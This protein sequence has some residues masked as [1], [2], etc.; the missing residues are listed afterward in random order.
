MVAARNDSAQ[1]PPVRT[2]A[3]RYLASRYVI[4]ALLIAFTAGGVLALTQARADAQTLTCNGQAVTISGSTNGDDVLRGTPGPDVF[5]A[6]RGNDTIYGGGGD[7]IICG[8]HGR[9][10]IYAGPG[11][12]YIDAGRNHDL[13]HGGEGNDIILGSFGDDT[14]WGDNGNDEIRGGAGRRD[15]LFGGGGN[16]D[17]CAGEFVSSATCERREVKIRPRRGAKSTEI[18]RPRPDLIT[19][20][21]AKIT[22]FTTQCTNVLFTLDGPDRPEPLVFA[23]RGYPDAETA[24]ENCFYDHIF[25]PG[26]WTSPL[27][28]DTQYELR[29][30]TI[31][32]TGKG[33]E[34]VVSFTTL[35]AVQPP[36]IDDD[37]ARATNRGSTT[38]A[39][40]VNTNECTNIRAVATTPVSSR[41]WVAQ[42]PDYPNATSGSCSRA[43][44]LT[45][46]GA[47]NPLLPG[48][49]YSVEVTVIDADGEI[50]TAYLR[51]TTD[52]IARPPTITNLK[53]T[54]ITA[55]SAVVTFNTDKC[56]NGRH[57]ANAPGKT[58]RSHQ[59][60]DWPTAEVPDVNCWTDHIARLG[61]WTGPLAPNTRYTATVTAIDGDGLSTT[62]TIT[63]TTVSA[64]TPPSIS[65]LEVND[66]TATTAR[67]TFT[68]D[69]CTNVEY[70]AAG[71]AVEPLLYRGADYPTAQVLGT[72]CWTEHSAV[73]GSVT[74]PLEPDTLYNVTITV[75]D[76]QGETSTSGISFTTGVVR[77]APVI[78]DVR[79]TEVTDTS[80]KITFTTD[81]CANGRFVAR[82]PGQSNRRTGGNE[83]PQADTFGI[84]CW[85]EHVSRLGV[86][87]TPLVPGTTYEVDMEVIDKDGLTAQQTISFATTAAA[88]LEIT[89]IAVSDVT[90]TTAKLTFATN[91]CAN[92]RYTA[93]SPSAPTKLGGHNNWPTADQPGVNCF[94]DH[95]YEIG[96]FNGALTP[97]ATYTLALEATDAN[98]RLAAGSITFTTSGGTNT[99]PP[100]ISN[101]Q[102]TDV[103]GTTATVTF[104]TDVCANG[105][106]TATASG[107]P[108]VR[109]GGAQWPTAQVPGVNCWTDHV[110]RF[111]DWTDDLVP[112]TSYSV[113][114]E[115]VD[116]A[117]LM[118]STTRTVTTPGAVQPA[119]AISNLQVDESAFGAVVTFNTNV[120]ANGR[121][122]VV[123]GGRT[124]VH[125]GDDWPRADTFGINCW[126]DHIARFGEWT[127]DLVP[128]T[129]YTLTVEAI[130]GDGDLR[131]ATATFTTPSP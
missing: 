105:R 4:V 73:L 49:D 94:T 93:T 131:T 116:G 120:C 102:V 17:F 10:E 44:S 24:G 13:V 22:F 77:K 51:F 1:F 128:G 45:L 114:I 2:R 58:P 61:E 79:V 98:A 72:N 33:A 60:A 103:T 36:V 53:V 91:R 30:Q 52:D 89:D 28:A 107:V 92:S 99:T 119:L 39:V 123:G 67:L 7:D 14:L 113:L 11:D 64:S 78:S 23:Y 125:G 65:N 108:T 112:G 106:Y 74:D 87:T 82:A 59:G 57:V 101:V 29:I 40:T 70:R 85:T 126:N 50:D 43:H 124:F 20:S 21:S 25:Q 118:S 27:R 6:Q 66:V 69:Q 76:G 130:D 34:R 71:S 88:T 26:I 96:R 37:T 122:T 35:G 5:H 129:F 110:A 81:E 95:T 83:W 41:S 80:A 75:I 48:A 47:S 15:A 100:E 104:N 8:G 115:V 127:D 19:S 111:G 42:G 18:R 12:D 117:G 56:S 55:N 121:H 3:S 84:N 46:G 31:D 62:D 109:W 54:G 68:T 97:G 32:R 9:D 38:A 16:N 86:W 63:F 90:A